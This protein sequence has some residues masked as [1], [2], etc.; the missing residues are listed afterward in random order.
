MPTDLAALARRWRLLIALVTA[1]RFPEFLRYHLQTTEARVRSQRLFKMVRERTRTPEQVFALLDSLERRAELFAALAD[2]LHEYWNERPDARPFIRELA[3]FHVRQVTPLLFCAYEVLAPAQFVS[4]LRMAS[5]LA[6]RWTVIGG[7]NTNA[8]ELPLHRA[9]AAILAG[10][11]GPAQV[12][13]LLNGVYVADGKFEEDMRGVTLETAG[14]R[15]RLGKY[16]LAR[17]EGDASGR[18]IDPE[19]DP[20][21]LEHILP[22]NPSPDW[23]ESFTLEQ[24]ENYTQR[25]G[26]LTLLE[27]TKN[28]DIGNGS[29]QAKLAAYATSTLR[30]NPADRGSGARGVDA[31]ANRGAAATPRRTGGSALADRLLSDLATGGVPAAHGVG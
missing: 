10:G 9:A 23:D 6:F 30:L 21:T 3:L 2:P 25:L 11:A 18:A 12:A 31:G 13:V 20:A 1:E 15:K 22:E 28:K 27:A 7:L 26:N 29:F 16:I 14:P 19:T 8:L 24:Q 5:V 4:V 17:L